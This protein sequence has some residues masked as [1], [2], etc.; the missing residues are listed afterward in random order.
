M[1]TTDGRRL[2]GH[3]TRESVLEAAVATASTAGLDGLSLAQLATGLGISKSA[4]FTHWPDKQTLQLAVIDQAAAQWADRIVRP[5]LDGRHGL[6]ALWAVQENRLA[7]Y[8]APVLPGRCFFVTAYTEF[9]DRPGPVQDRLRAQLVQWEAF[10]ANL[11]RESITAGELRPE[12]PVQLLAFE[13]DA[14]GQAVVTRARLLEADTVFAEARAALLAR[15][16]HWA[17]RPDTLPAA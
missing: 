9:D 5:A 12:T 4:L 8:A 7:F 13:L 15:L 3:R 6:A 2:R 16:R 17:T 14:L 1:P 11:I 10:Q